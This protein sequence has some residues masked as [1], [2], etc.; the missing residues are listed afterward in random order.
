MS[1]TYDPNDI[2]NPNNAMHF[3]H[4]RAEEARSL[5]RER[6]ERNKLQPGAR[7]TET[8]VASASVPAPSTSHPGIPFAFHMYADRLTEAIEYLVNNN[9]AMAN[10]PCAGANNVTPQHLRNSLRAVRNFMMSN[11]PLGY[12]LENLTF[13]CGPKGVIVRDKR[14]S[15]PFKITAPISLPGSLMPIVATPEVIAAVAVLLNAKDETGQPAEWPD[16][17]LAVVEEENKQPY[18]DLMRQSFPSWWIV[19]MPSMWVDIKRKK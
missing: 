5:Q 16:F 10:V 1:E 15:E 2:R 12:A 17:F 18:N 11:P 3:I 19:G 13:T 7:L 8:T 9:Y 4:L 6:E 14:K